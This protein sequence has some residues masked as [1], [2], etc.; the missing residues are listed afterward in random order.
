MV[1]I[2][3]HQSEKHTI[4]LKKCQKHLVLTIREDKELKLE[5]TTLWKENKQI[6]GGQSYTTLMLGIFFH[7]SHDKA[8]R[9]S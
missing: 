4:K 1:A 9:P 8:L 2:E 7:R 3:E 5:A 6:A